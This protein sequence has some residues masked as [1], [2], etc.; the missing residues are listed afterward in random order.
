MKVSN[1]LGVED[2]TEELEVIV[3][4]KLVVI[5]ATT[6]ANTEAKIIMAAISKPEITSFRAEVR[7]AAVVADFFADFCSGR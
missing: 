6:P 4:G 5:S 1:K 7:H 3:R 2:E